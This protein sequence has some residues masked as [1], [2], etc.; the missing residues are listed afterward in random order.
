[1][2]MTEKNILVNSC[3]LW[4]LIVFVLVSTLSCI[5]K[6][7]VRIPG[8][9]GGTVS[10]QKEPQ[11]SVLD[12]R[13]RDA[14]N[15]C[16]EGKYQE[17]ASIYE[18]LLAEYP[19]DEKLTPMLLSRL[20]KV[21]LSLGDYDTSEKYGKRILSEFPNYYG[22]SEVHVDLIKA[23]IGKGNLDS[24]LR[25][26]QKLWGYLGN[27]EEKAHLAYLLAQIFTE[28]RDGLDAFYWLLEAEKLAAGAELKNK[29]YSQMSKVV[30]L[31]NEHQV[32]SLIPEF[33]GHFP[34][35]WLETRLVEILIDKG[36][37][38]KATEQLEYLT[39]SFPMH[40]LAE[41][42]KKLQEA[43]DQQQDVDVNAIGCL[44]PLTG[45]LQPYGRRLLRGLYM[46]QELYNL[47]TW[48]EPVKIIVKDSH[49]EKGVSKAVDEL[50]NNHHVLAIIGPLSRKVVDEAAEE[51]QKLRVPL[52][53]LTQRVD[54]VN[55][56]DYIFRVFLTN[57]DQARLLVAYAVG[58]LGLHT[59]GILYP[60]DNYGHYFEKAFSE[61]LNKLPVKL[62]ARVGYDPGTTDFT[63]PIRNLFVQAGIPL[64]THGKKEK[65]ISVL[66]PPAFDAIFLPDQVQ[67]A[68]LIASQLVYNDVVGVRLFGT[69]LWNTPRLEK[70]YA[71]YLEGAIFVGGFFAGSAKPVVQQ[72]VERFEAS[73]DEKP[74]YL[75]AQAYDVLNLVLTARNHAECQTRGAIRTELLR[76]RDFDGVT[77]KMSM[78]PNGDAQKELFLLTVRNGKIIELR[79]DQKQ[80]YLKLGTI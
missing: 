67:T 9:P 8:Y 52:I 3:R 21:C 64:P 55:I 49:G 19:A 36:E 60:E 61:E 73:Y 63:R 65:P 71:P 32:K 18:K 43:I 14:E 10:P 70:E 50:V 27:P 25:D 2:N 16:Y 7:S 28:K 20:Q 76:I 40:P 77:G 13:L 79:V 66:S 47:S 5:P 80:L 12:Q 46:A 53:T 29:I 68:S 23:G 69:N 33:K 30:S 74:Q 26:G 1:M 54:V 62:M 38:N 51:A 44:L 78:L 37:L 4:L 34:D 31:L 35:L 72:F 24:A 41:K 6:S 42:F 57:R 11:Q 56:G 22:I 75:E 48:E 39:R 15:L 17:C 45:P 59:F 58:E